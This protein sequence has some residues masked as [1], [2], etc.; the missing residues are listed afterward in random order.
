MLLLVVQT[1]LSN[2]HPVGIGRVD[3]GAELFCE[4]LAVG[5]GGFFAVDVVAL[6]GDFLGFVVKDV[7]ICLLPIV[8]GQLTIL[9]PLRTLARPA[10]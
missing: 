8:V 5:L 1:D 2:G 3:G 10:W 4:V 6:V 9:H 7:P